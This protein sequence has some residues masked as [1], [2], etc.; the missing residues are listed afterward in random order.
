MSDTVVNGMI[1]AS[2]SAIASPGYLIVENTRLGYVLLPRH[3]VALIGKPKPKLSSRAM[4]PFVLFQKRDRFL[5]LV[6]DGSIDPQYSIR[7][8]VRVRIRAP[9]VS[10]G[11]CYSLQCRNFAS[12]GCF[13]GHP[14]CGFCR[15]LTALD[16][17]LASQSVSLIRRFSNWTTDCLKNLHNH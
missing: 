16:L 2:L 10:F 13:R 14:N 15:A 3:A 8:S 1:F 6:A 17:A 12:L 7:L 11:L 9:L 4:T 5:I